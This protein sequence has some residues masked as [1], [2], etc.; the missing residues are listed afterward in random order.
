MKQINPEQALH[1]LAAYCSRAERCVSDVRRKMEAW[2]IPCEEQSRIIGRLTQEKF[3]D[4]GRYCRAFVNDKSKYNHWGAY[5]IKYELAKKQIPGH[6]IRE[7]LEN[8]DSEENLEQL[9]LLLEQK[10]KSIKGKNEFEI[11]QKLMRF[12]ASRGFSQ[13]EIE[14]A[15]G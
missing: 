9:R 3:L 12:A 5:K 11:R 14:K 15:L 1:R 6:L 13:G 2:E 4:E 8:I 10:R 7:A